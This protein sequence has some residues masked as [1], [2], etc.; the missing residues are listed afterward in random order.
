MNPQENNMFISNE[1]E[2]DELDIVYREDNG[3]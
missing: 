3:I 2:A 1:I